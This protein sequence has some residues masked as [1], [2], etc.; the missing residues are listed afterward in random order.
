M[1]KLSFLSAILG[2]TFAGAA[3]AADITVYY[4]PTCPHC[5]HAREFIAST[6]VYEYPELKVTEVNVMDEA[7]LP[8]FQETLKKCEFES[9]GVPV[10][11]VGDKCEQGYADFMQDTL[12]QHVEVDLNDEQKAA[13]AANKQ[14]MS[15]D[16]EKFKAEHADRANAISE[17]NAATVAAEEVEKKSEGGNVIWFWGLL[18]VLVAGLGYVLVRKDKK[19]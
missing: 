3:S 11:V 8:M 17:Y 13:A 9:G 10:I 14:A 12:R 18:I 1:K 6:L 2:L 4:S 7:N 19:K 5:H 16:A 15:E